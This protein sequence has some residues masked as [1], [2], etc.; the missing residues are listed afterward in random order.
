M[1]VILL[2]A[3][4]KITVKPLESVPDNFVTKIFYDTNQSDKY[5]RNICKALIV[6]PSF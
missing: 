4:D 2:E 5:K 6:L 1:K 3:N